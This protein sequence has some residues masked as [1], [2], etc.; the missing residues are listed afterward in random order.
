M[1]ERGK[2][3]KEDRKRERKT[4]FLPSDGG[5]LLVDWQRLCPFWCSWRFSCC[6]SLNWEQT[7][8]HCKVA[9]HRWHSITIIHSVYLWP[10]MLSDSQLCF[11]P[12]ICAWMKINCYL[13]CCARDVFIL[14]TCF[15]STFFLWCC[16]L[17][18]KWRGW[19]PLQK[20]TDF[21]NN[22]LTGEKE[23]WHIPSISSKV[24]FVGILVS[25]QNTRKYKLFIFFT[26]FSWLISEALC[27][28]QLQ[29]S[30]Q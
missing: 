27:G 4:E 30:Q 24:V 29:R 6:F 18:T 11:V 9:A 3:K 21:P 8:K 14:W 19:N 12:L 2:R 7:V 28:P 17:E 26:Y 5:V 22:F 25:F 10:M 1:G 15:R 23:F 20:C 13:L 16:G